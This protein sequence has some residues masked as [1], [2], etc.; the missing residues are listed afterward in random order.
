MIK[1]VVVE[2]QSKKFLELKPYPKNGHPRVVATTSEIFEGAIL[3]RLDHLKIGCNYLFH[4]DGS[5]MGYR[6]VQ[7]RYNK[8]LKRC[9]LY[10]RFS[11]PHILSYSTATLRLLQDITP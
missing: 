5:P 9:G 10:P 11:S 8:A 2:D 3:R 1:E 4:E 7:Y 6:K